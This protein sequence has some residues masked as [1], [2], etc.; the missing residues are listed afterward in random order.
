VRESHTRSYLSKNTMKASDKALVFYPF[1]LVSPT[2]AVWMGWPDLVLERGGLADL[3]ELLELLNYLGRSESWVEASL[4]EA[5]GE[6]NCVPLVDGQRLEGG[7]IV[8]VAC[9]EGAERYSAR[10]LLVKKKPLSWLEAV[11]L[12]TEDL[13]RRKLGRHPMINEVSYVQARL[14][15]A[16]R[17][18]SR[19]DR[20]ISAVAFSLAGPVLPAIEE[21][22]EIADQVRMRLLG[23]DKRLHGADSPRHPVFSGKTASGERIPGHGHLFVLP[24]DATGSGRIDELL[25]LARRGFDESAQRVL[26]ELRKLYLRGRPAVMCTL[27]GLGSIEDLTR[28]TQVVVS[29]TPF[30]PPRHYKAS[31]GP[32]E[33]WLQHELRRELGHHNLP[34]PVSIAPV[35]RCPTRTRG[36]RRWIG[37]RRNRK[38]DRPRPGF[39]FRVEFAEPVLAPFTLGY[40]CHFG[41]GLFEVDEG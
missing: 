6:P 35:A 14:R 41:L 27:S 28:R 38:T 22:L 12:T 5:P 24:R 40:G 16:V 2:Q 20:G 29:R 30:V 34:A 15:R 9:P 23:I 3:A 32:F 18:R 8:T 39:G 21:T 13:R 10:P 1:V 33:A 31:R 4:A 19:L 17:T 25:I 37:F 36:E 26:D 11:S 7:S